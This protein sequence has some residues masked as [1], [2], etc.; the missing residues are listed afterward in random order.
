MKDV[1]RLRR[2]R[3]RVIAGVA[4]GI[5][6]HFD[7]D[8]LVVRVA[9][10][11]LCFFGGAGLVLYAAG[12]LL[13]PEDG[14]EQ[15]PLHL[16]ERSR[17][18]AL[19]IAVAIA[20][21]AM[22][23]DTSGL[24][25]FPWPLAVVAVVVWFLYSRSQERRRPVPPYGQPGPYQWT[26]APYGPQQP[27]DAAPAEGVQ[28]PP[29]APYGT[30]PGSYAEQVAQQATQQATQQASQYTAAY[31]PS[32]PYAAPP[33][34]PPVQ[35][36]YGTPYAGAPVPPPPP[37]TRP[38]DPRRRGPILF[39]FTLALVALAMGIL[40]TVDLAGVDV[41]GSA[42]P[43]LALTVVSVMLVVGAFWGRAGGLVLLALVAAG[44]TVG[45]AAAENWETEQVRHTPSSASEVRS[46][47][48][49]RQG[50]LVVDL[51]GVEDLAELNGRVVQADIGAGRLE[52][53]L[54]DELSARVNADVGAGAVRVSG[55]DERSGLGVSHSYGVSARVP[56]PDAPVVRLELDAGVGEIVVRR[57]SDPIDPS[58]PANR[59]AAPL[60]QH[61]TRQEALR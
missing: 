19:V 32:S 36:P 29:T 26:G 4:S 23:G 8:P 37:L 21:V 52:V 10:V 16:D 50:D 38:R 58:D 17:T 31:A 20:T 60:E 39:G 35:P 14:A 13:M 56:G 43:A 40:G 42:Y 6:R 46:D 47:Y 53:V 51:S 44:V 11:V 9:L 15:A 27:T 59:G 18:V 24:Y 33:A 49:L 34:Q 7:V 61:D 54:P 28:P 12:W 55:S 22:L 30:G 45:V 57:E 2:P 48:D 1:N 5:A 41:V 3:Q 25:W